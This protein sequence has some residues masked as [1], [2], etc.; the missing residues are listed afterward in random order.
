MVLM[1][2]C[3]QGLT[4]SFFHLFL[5]LWLLFVS[6]LPSLSSCFSFLMSTL[7]SDFVLLLQGQEWGRGAGVFLRHCPCWCCLQVNKASV[8]LFR[9]FFLHF[10]PVK[11][12]A[13]RLFMCLHA[14][15]HKD[16]DG[17]HLPPLIQTLILL[18]WLPH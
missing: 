11:E 6:L 9:G 12:E 5:L 17:H 1:N 15:W 13:G 8:V 2:H 14:Q 3:F 10:C 4:G 18:W 7:L 16:E